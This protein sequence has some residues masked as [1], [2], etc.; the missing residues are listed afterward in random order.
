MPRMRHK[1]VTQGH[2]HARSEL[3]SKGLGLDPT[4]PRRTCHC[5][6]EPVPEGKETPRWCSHCAVGCQEWRGQMWRGPRCPLRQWARD[7]GL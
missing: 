5:C 1:I 3:E 6:G 4:L 2:R 7:Q